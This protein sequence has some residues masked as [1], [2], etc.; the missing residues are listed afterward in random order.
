M[1]GFIDQLPAENEAR[2]PHANWA[3]CAEV[4]SISKWIAQ[5]TRVAESDLI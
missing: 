1:L 2:I 5:S 3:A 4:V